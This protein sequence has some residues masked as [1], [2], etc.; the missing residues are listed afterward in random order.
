MGKR[1]QNRLRVLLV[2]DDEEEYFLTQG[3]LADRSYRTP[4]SPQSRFHLEWVDSYVAA[5]KA[6]AAKKHDVYLVDYQLRDRDGLQLIREVT[7]RGCSAPI[8]LITGHGSYKLD[9]EA[10]QAGATDYLVKGEIT[11]ALLERTIRYALERKR[12]EEEILQNASRA[13]LLVTL[14]QTF[15]KASLNY[16]DVLN[17]ITGQIADASGD[18]CVIHLLA[19]DKCSL[20]P[21]A[22]Y[23][24][25]PAILSALSDALAGTRQRIDP[26]LA[27]QLLKNGR[28]IFFF[29]AETSV[30]DLRNQLGQWSW[31]N[32]IPAYSVLALP[33]R[34]E[35]RLV[36]VLSILKLRAGASY[37]VAD[38]SFFQDLADRAALAIETARLYAAES[39]RAR[40]LDALQTATAALLTTIDLEILLGHILDTAQSA[41]PAADKGALHLIAPET[42]ELQIRAA[43]GYVD[44]R[45][46]RL[47]ISGSRAYPAR[48]VRER[49]P[50]LI[51][52]ALADPNFPDP[53]SLDE[54]Q[55]LRSAVV[56]PLILGENLLGA[57][58]LSASRPSAFTEA[59]LRLLV[60][61]ATTTTAAL[62]NAFLHAEVKKL[63][64]TDPLTD[65]HNR[66][67]FFD[68]G[69]REVER[70]RRFGRSLSLIMMD[71]DGFKV[72][73]DVYGHSV[74]DQVLRIL[75]GRL[76]SSV[77]EVDIL[78]RYGGDEF[79]VLLPETD[80]FTAR[81]VAE[82]IR[83]QVAEPLTLPDL[84][85]PECSLVVTAS[86]GVAHAVADTLTLASLL[87]RA[88]AAAYQAKRRGRNTIEVG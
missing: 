44:Q 54:A 8:I 37:T 77:R 38:Q 5:L 61:F 19:C 4:G 29:A 52:D 20:E 24:P 40:E 56:A 39:S 80:L 28:P 68:L 10:M 79:V 11:A 22:F 88:D 42:G 76:R 46:K 9:V 43:S 32:S 73:N 57:V 27:G 75:T 6:F 87:E 15:A 31:L 47:A 85:S 78:G 66:R 83:L 3:L 26:D 71:L 72:V 58:S 25:D 49:C 65:I 86:L 21:A 2:D 74:G 55:V 82:R 14:S 81:V 16:P 53:D 18:A 23:H 51:H 69:Q 13:E 45:I 62:Q 50:L 1:P 41:I 33:L 64:R 34:A 67:G 30:G 48:A 60:S 84:L 7:A 12:A 63:A 35:G 59:D 17:V 36:G 70:A